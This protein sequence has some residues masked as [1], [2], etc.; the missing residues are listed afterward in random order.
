MTLITNLYLYGPDGT[1][2]RNLTEGAFH[3]EDVLAVGDGFLL[4]PTNCSGGNA[5]MASPTDTGPS[6]MKV[7]PR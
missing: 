2:K 4:A 3:V 7:I 6:W 1:L 5:T